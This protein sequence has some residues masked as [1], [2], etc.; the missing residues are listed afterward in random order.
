M[1]HKLT[2]FFAHI[3]KK[4]E[5]SIVYFWGRGKTQLRRFNAAKVCGLIFLAFGILASS[6]FAIALGGYLSISSINVKKLLVEKKEQLF[7]YQIQYDGIFENTYNKEKP[8]VKEVIALAETPKPT[9]PVKIDISPWLSSKLS[10]LF[11]IKK[12]SILTS[13]DGESIISFSLKNTSGSR[14]TGYAWAV[15]LIEDAD[16]NH[17]FAG[18]PRD[19]VVLN[20][21]GTFMDPSL[22]IKYRFKKRWDNEYRFVMPEAKGSKIKRMVLLFSDLEGNIVAQHSLEPLSQGLQQQLNSH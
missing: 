20:A 15:S 22:A 14:L 13:D 7:S 5:L 3:S 11:L 9:P 19:K 2:G 4:E 18:V 17:S 21:D 10:S 1:L 16:G 12:L 6:I 8:A